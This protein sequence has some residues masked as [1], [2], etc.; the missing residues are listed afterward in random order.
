MDPSPAVV[1][2]PVGS[3]LTETA[4][5]DEASA[6]KRDVFGVPIRLAA[7]LGV[8]A[9]FAPMLLYSA[10]IHH[11]SV[12][13]MLTMND[14]PSIVEGYHKV[15]DIGHAFVRYWTAPWIQYSIY[16]FRPVS[17]FLYWLETD[18]GF[19][20]GF[21]W[22]AWFG[23]G[24]YAVSVWLC[25]LITYRFTR[26]PLLTV[27]GAVFAV[28]IRLYNGGQPDMWLAWYPI[29]QDL[30]MMVFILAAVVSFDHWLE[31]ES[32]TSLAITWVAFAVGCLTKEYL[33]AF[34]FMA[35]TM[36]ML[37]PRSS[38]LSKR[39]AVVQ[40]ALFVATVL[41]LIVVRH[42]MYVHPRD[43]HF[44]KA[45]ILHKPLMFM[46]SEIGL[47]VLTGDYGIVTLAAVT[48]LEAG[49][50]LMLRH[51]GV[52]FN[53]LTRYAV[54]LPICL[55][56]F[57]LTQWLAAGSALI[58]LFRMLEVGR[59]VDEYVTACCLIYTMILAWK[60]RRASWVSTVW[61]LVFFSYLPV[62]SFIGWH[63]TMPGA[64]FRSI[65]WPIIFQAAM[66]DVSGGMAKLPEP[67]RAG[68]DK[69]YAAVGGPK[70]AAESGAGMAGQVTAA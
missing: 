39:D 49:V 5:P 59:S 15:P 28:G 63:Y 45:V 66:V 65:Y 3:P 41:V 10:F 56:L 19:K 60:Y 11:C 57:A 22:D 33:F 30:L 1:T 21:I 27:V 24:L 67:I 68:W 64:L 43:P 62:I 38:T 52:R 31:T 42:I 50:L 7:L 37:R 18:I 61:M 29:H 48:M 12:A 20:H 32:K 70:L 54:V 13:E 2:Y 46:Y 26:S 44:R 34:P 23:Y 16:C 25:S 55:G 35:A 69:L 36:A 14:V 8:I 51:R 47:T 6:V 40:V 53:M 17:G 4:V 9:L 58:S